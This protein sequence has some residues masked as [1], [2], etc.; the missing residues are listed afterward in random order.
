MTDPR[1]IIAVLCAAALVI[2][3][4]LTL[5][6]SYHRALARTKARLAPFVAV[7]PRAGNGQFRSTKVSA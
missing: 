2:G 4:L 3:G 6:V 1:I 5:V 7:R